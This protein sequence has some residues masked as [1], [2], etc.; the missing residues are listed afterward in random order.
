MEST[1]RLFDQNPYFKECK[2]N[3]LNEKIREDGLYDLVLDQTTFYPTGGGQP[4]DIGWMNGIA[5]KDVYKK[6]GVIFHVLESSIGDNK[7]VACKIDW[8]RRYDHMQQHAGQHILSRAFESLFEAMTVGFHLGE[9]TITIDVTLKELTEEIISSVEELSNKIIMDNRQII[10]EMVSVDELSDNVKNKIPDIEE[11]VR[12]VEVENFDRIA[13]SG[14]H[15]N[16]TSEIGF[17]KILGWEKY[18]QNVRVT[19]ASGKR[20]LNIFSKFQ[21]ELMNAASILKTNWAD[22]SQNVL[23]TIEDK[24]RLEKKLKDLN[25]QLIQFEI[26]ELKQKAQFI[27]KFHYIEA[28]FENRDFNEIRQLAQGITQE[29]S[30]VILFTNITEEKVQFLLN[31]SDDLQVSMNECLKIGLE[32]I[33]GKG[34]GNPK[35]AQGGGTNHNK[36]NETIEAMKKYIFFSLKAQPL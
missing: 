2:A 23:R 31:R 29:S 22:V 20:L 14:T 34:G 11:Y 35:V 1:K 3:I 32:I 7:D 26:A 5:V 9:E 36:L 16:S 25:L 28:V 33:E 17:I 21:M 27:G 12:I 8:D 13:C 10:K 18:K 30:Y 6:N 4:H 19:F 15:P 24:E